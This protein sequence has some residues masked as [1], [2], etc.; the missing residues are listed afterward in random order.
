MNNY[1][2]LR[3]TVSGMFLRDGEMSIEKYNYVYRRN[4]SVRNLRTSPNFSFKSVN[5]VPFSGTKIWQKHI[6]SEKPFSFF[7]SEDVFWFVVLFNLI[8]ITAITR[9]LDKHI[10]L[11]LTTSSI[12]KYSV[13]MFMESFANMYS[14]IVCSPY[15]AFEMNTFCMKLECQISNR[16]NNSTLSP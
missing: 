14:Y 3:C 16:H 15:S 2:A 11:N 10:L 9:Q 8:G 13:M 6:F 4:F 12:S 1:H 5:F 7:Y